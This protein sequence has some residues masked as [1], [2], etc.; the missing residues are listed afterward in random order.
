MWP[1]KTKLERKAIE[2][3]NVLTN[4]S[5][6]INSEAGRDIRKTIAT[7]LLSEKYAMQELYS[8]AAFINKA[9][10]ETAKQVK[11]HLIEEGIIGKKKEE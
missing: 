9:G 8:K 10:I 7:E 6:P 2:V 4:L 3:N 11:Q 1:F 5:I